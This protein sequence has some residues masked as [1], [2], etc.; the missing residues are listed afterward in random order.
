VSFSRPFVNAVLANSR[1]W[2]AVEVFETSDAVD[3][4]ATITKFKAKQSR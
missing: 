3:L 2:L 4:L 1:S